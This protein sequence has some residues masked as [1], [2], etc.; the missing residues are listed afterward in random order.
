METKCCSRCD[1]TK[2]IQ[3]FI[4]ARNICKECSNKWNKI[5]REKLY[6]KTISS[7]T[8]RLCNLCNNTKSIFDFMKNSHHCKDCHNEKRRKRYET[9]EEH[10]KKMIESAINSKVI[11]KERYNKRQREKYHTDP[12][13]KFMCNQRS[14]IAIALSKKQKHTIDYLD[15]NAEQYFQWL[16]FQFNDETFTFENHG[17]V[18]H[19]DHVIPL[20]K[21]NLE[22]E[23]Q[24]SLAFNWRNT[25]P[26]FISENLEK[27]VK[28]NSSQIEQHY[29]T[30]LEY[31]KKNNIELPQKFIDLYAKHLVAG[32]SLEP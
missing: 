13:F 16:Q 6:Q 3:K 25:M 11:H 10:R 26:L 32:S 20:S 14:R 2:E 8:E 9:D 24:Q 29:K 4:K 19:V 1:E 31:H 18:W 17:S 15:C 5:S 7:E 23:E 28:I 22:N 12:V 21:F 27:G 30:L